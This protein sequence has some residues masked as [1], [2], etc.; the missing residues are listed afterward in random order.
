MGRREPLAQG[1]PGPIPLS[2]GVAR[3]PGGTFALTLRPPI[4][5]ARE[6]DARG[7]RTRA[8]QVLCRRSQ[9]LRL[10]PL[11]RAAGGRVCGSRRGA[12]R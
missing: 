11:G 1:R 3:V 4:V 2:G 12:G 6:P 5:T 8:F 7:V 10:G 9:G